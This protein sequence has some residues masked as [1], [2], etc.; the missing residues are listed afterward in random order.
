MAHKLIVAQTSWN[1]FRV[2][3]IPVNYVLPSR[4]EAGYPYGRKAHL[5]ADLWEHLEPYRPPGVLWVD[6]DVAGDLDDLEAME[7]AAAASPGNVYTGVLKLWPIST[8]RSDWIWS[9]RGGT[10]GN[11]VATKDETVPIA[12][13]AMG[14]LWTP[15]RLL[16]AAFPQHRAWQYHEIDVGLSELALALGIPMYRVPD[17]RPKHLH[18]QPEHHHGYVVPGTTG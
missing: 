3:G 13:V 2:K 18:F 17:C 11:P 15:A 7:L 4:A 10:M 14:F 1:G 12:Y 16:S 6:P 9:H 5:M 8:G